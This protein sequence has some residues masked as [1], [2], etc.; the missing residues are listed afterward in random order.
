MKTVIFEEPWML[1]I[2]HKV[3]GWKWARPKRAPWGESTVL[4]T[5]EDWKW[6]R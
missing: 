6:A 3:T 1:W 2:L 4:W 5:E